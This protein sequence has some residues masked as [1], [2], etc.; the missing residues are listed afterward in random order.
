MGSVRGGM[1]AADLCD[2]GGGQA[3]QGQLPPFGQLCPA[4]SWGALA[5]GYDGVQGSARKLAA[6][7]ERA[8]GSSVQRSRK[9]LTVTTKMLASG[10]LQRRF[11][12]R[13]RRARWS[14]RSV[15]TLAG[16]RPERSRHVTAST[17]AAGGDQPGPGSQRGPGSPG[18]LLPPRPIPR[19]LGGTCRGRGVATS[20]GW[21][22]VPQTLGHPLLTASRENPA[23]PRCGLG[24]GEGHDKP[25]K[26][27]VR[28]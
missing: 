16:E 23:V 28:H 6:A 24:A 17:A 5:L 27:G 11:P 14:L 7:T 21:D 2:L 22:C 15:L 25:R 13:C 20:R 10:P 4:Q 8:V 1:A 26:A 18:A 12:V 19:S 3:C 9:H